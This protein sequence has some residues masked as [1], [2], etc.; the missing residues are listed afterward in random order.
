MAGLAL[1]VAATALT[2]VLPVAGLLVSLAAITL[3][4]AA[5]RAQSTLAVRRSVRGPRPSDPLL[6]VVM[7]P[8]TVA[9]ALLA[10]ALMAPVAFFVGAV[11]YGATLVLTH[12]LALP[13]AGAYAAAAVV[14]WYGIGPGSGRP[15]RQLNR[16][17]GALSR[18]PISATATALAVWAVAAAAVILA[19]SQVPDYWPLMTPHLPALHGWPL[20]G[21]HLPRLG[22]LVSS[23]GNWL[24]RQAH[25]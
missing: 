14:V 20:V 10:E 1:M 18:T 19:A 3:L 12:S 25:T 2:V 22:A 4:R 23:A 8:L 24:F 5:D 13:Q 7:A 16:M 6:V 11:T 15:R 9:R 17:A 21:P